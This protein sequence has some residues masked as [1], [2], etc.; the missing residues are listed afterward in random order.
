METILNGQIT[1]SLVVGIMAKIM[2]VLLFL[3]SL[4]MLRQTAL[5]DKVIKIPVGGSIKTLVWSFSA[6]LLLLTVIVV[7]A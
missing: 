6:L 3:M 2:M 1:V 4:V 5:M 7:L